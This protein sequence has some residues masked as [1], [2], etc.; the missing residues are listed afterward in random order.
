LGYNTYKHGNITRKLTVWLPLL[1]TSKNVFSSFFFFS[2]T[3]LEN[4]RVEQV[5]EGGRGEAE[6]EGR[7]GTQHK[8]C[9]QMYINAKN[10]TC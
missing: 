5:L 8:N 3:K 6:K 10:D 7:K 2:S 4:R 9:V 1:Q